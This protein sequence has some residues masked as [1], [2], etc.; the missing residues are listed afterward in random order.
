[1]AGSSNKKISVIIV[2][3]GRDNYLKLCLDSLKAQSC[4]I[5]EHVVV[6]NS[7]NF[8]FIKEIKQHYPFIK[9]YSSKENLFYCQALNIGIKMSNGEFILC[10]NDDV[11]LEQKYIEEA[12]KV[13]DINMNIGMVSGKVLR[14]DKKTIDTAGMFLSIFRTVKER[15]YGVKDTGQ[16]EKEEYIF[17]VNGAV[18][19]YR[20]QMLEEIKI[21]SDYFDPDYHIFYE[22]LDIAWRAQNFGWKAYYAPKAIAYHIRGATVRVNYGI[23]KPYARR[24]LSNELHLDLIK[25]RYLTLIKN[26]SVISFLL[27]LPLILFYDILAW[28]YVL[29]LCPGLIIKFFLNLKYLSDAFNKRRLI[30]EAQLK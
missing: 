9:S 4:V 3:A 22:D 24:Y 6:D 12:I 14:I 7:L 5:Y 16:Y 18:A 11:I 27:H 23:D 26:E 19:F 13:F 17:G 25:N 20:K 29:F 10:L 30:K 15:G 8:N 1:M 28:G 21:G 2:T